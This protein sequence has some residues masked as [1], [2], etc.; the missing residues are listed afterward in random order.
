MC[1]MKTITLQE[2]EREFERWVGEVEAGE[3]FV[4]T[5]DGVPIAKLE[6]VP[7]EHVLTPEQ[8]AALRR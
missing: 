6:P 2:A 8:E 3:V 4:I 5:R 1:Y 7:G